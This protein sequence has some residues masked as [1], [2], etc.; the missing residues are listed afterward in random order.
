MILYELRLVN[1]NGATKKS[2]FLNDHF[3]N[4]MKPSEDNQENNSFLNKYVES[5]FSELKSYFRGLKG[6]IAL[7]MRDSNT[8]I[9]PACNSYIAASNVF[10]KN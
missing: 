7:L 9:Y 1:E 10:Y 4:I 2:I 3:L 5:R 6:G 8:G